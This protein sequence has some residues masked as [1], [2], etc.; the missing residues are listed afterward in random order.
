MLNILHLLVW[1]ALNV[2]ILG[3]VLAADGC[4]NVANVTVL[5]LLESL[6]DE[7]V[8]KDSTL[9][10]FAPLQ[11]GGARLLGSTV[12]FHNSLGVQVILR[13]AVLNCS[14]LAPL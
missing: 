6:L 1:T 2:R 11:L 14:L 13:L 8:L 10:E 12:N 4:A 3:W 9:L 7:L 5:V